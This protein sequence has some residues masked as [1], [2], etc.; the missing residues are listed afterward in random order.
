MYVAQHPIFHSKNTNQNEK[1]MELVLKTYFTLQEQFGFTS[2]LHQIKH[3]SF[4]IIIHISNNEFQ[5]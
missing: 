3:H 1:N 5:L 4:E 2:A